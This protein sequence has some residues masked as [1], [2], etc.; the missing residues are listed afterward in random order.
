VKFD[1]A[2]DVSAQKFDYSKRVEYSLYETQFRL[3]KLDLKRQRFSYLPTAAAYGSLGTSAQRTEFDVF[4]FSKPWYPTALIGA[5]V[6]L[7]IFTGMARHARTEQAKVSMMKAE[8]DLDFVKQSI[9]LEL[10]TSAVSLQN[11]SATLET[12]KKNIELAQ[13]VYRVSKIKFEQGVGSNLEMVTAETTLKEAQTNY[14]NAL[15]D[16]LV[17]KID[18]DKANGTLVK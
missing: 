9:D 7:P 14:F 16:A 15:Y 2:S 3:S 8:N 5:T 10:A 11:A 13:D 12:Q 1:V 6:K 18:Y 17:S 4:D